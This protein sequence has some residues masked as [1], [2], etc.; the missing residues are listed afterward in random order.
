[1]T[2]SDSSATTRTPATRTPATNRRPADRRPAAK[3]NAPGDALAL[4]I[5]LTWAVAQLGVIVLKLP[6]VVWIAPAL[7]AAMLSLLVGRRRESVVYLWV[8]AMF[9]VLFLLA[10][11]PGEPAVP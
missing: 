6:T 11:E 1:M 8:A 3:P 4:P 2:R 7:V 9:C 10:G 5:V